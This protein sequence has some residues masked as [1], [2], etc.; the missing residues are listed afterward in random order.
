M[1]VHFNVI[2]HKLT[3]ENHSGLKNIEVKYIRIIS[4]YIIEFLWNNLGNR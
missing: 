1:Y 2:P 3:A 4:F